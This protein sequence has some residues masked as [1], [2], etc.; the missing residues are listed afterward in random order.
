M[1]KEIMI[2]NA[3]LSFPNLFKAKAFQDSDPKYSA[4]FMI[5]KDDPQVKM[6]TGLVKELTAEFKGA[7]FKNHAIADG[8]EEGRE[9]CKGM[10]II[11]AKASA[12]RKPLTVDMKARIRDDAA[13]QKEMY[14]GCYVNADL[15]FYTLNNAYGKMLCCGLNAVQKF[16]EGEHLGSVPTNRFS[17]LEEESAPTDNTDSSSDVASLFG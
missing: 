8:D 16:S 6:L 17:A 11:K 12:D 13:F 1:R 9:E 3:R 15:S 14:A 7:K 5:S 2:N 10:I 4:S